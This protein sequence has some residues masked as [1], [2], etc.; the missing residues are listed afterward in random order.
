MSTQHL[1]LWPPRASSNHQNSTIGGR[2]GSG[3]T[4][5]RSRQKKRVVS[6]RVLPTILL[7]FT[8]QA[9]AKPLSLD[10]SSMPQPNARNIRADS[11]DHEE[12]L[13]ESAE[14][15]SLLQKEVAAL[16]VPNLASAEKIPL[17]FHSYQEFDSFLAKSDFERLKNVSSHTFPVT[18]QREREISLMEGSPVMGPGHSS[19]DVLMGKDLKIEYSD[20]FGRARRF[21][22]FDA[23]AKLESQFTDV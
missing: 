11:H 4:V 23:R 21:D 16:P 5:K 15:P 13:R 9:L 3:R 1:E 6:A 20:V 2:P 18:F 7:L 22:H 17:Q 14:M 19:L 8:M 10:T 12:T